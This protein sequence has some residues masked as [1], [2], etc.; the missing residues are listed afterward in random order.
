MEKLSL[1]E[2]LNY[3]V[4][5]I[6]PKLS[7]EDKENIAGFLE[8]LQNEHSLYNDLN[9][10]KEVIM[11]NWNPS[12]CPTCGHDFRDYEECNDGYYDRAY[13]ERCPYCGQKL[14]WS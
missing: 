1:S 13:L 11:K 7:S 9:V 3:F 8:Y 5:N 12:E 10:P 6:L 2:Q 14:K 4:S